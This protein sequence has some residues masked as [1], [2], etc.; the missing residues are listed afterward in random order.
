MAKLKDL[1]GLAALGA[2]GYQLSQKDQGQ[3]DNDTLANAN[4]ISRMSDDSNTLARVNSNISPGQNAVDDTNAGVLNAISKPKMAADTSA[5]STTANAYPLG[6]M[7]GSRQKTAAKPAAKLAAK[8]MSDAQSDM[9]AKAGRD[10]TDAQNYGNESIRPVTP[11]MGSKSPAG[12]RNPR[13]GRPMPF[14]DTAPTSTRTA[15]PLPPGA[16]FVPGFGAVDEND[17]IIPGYM[18]GY[19]PDAATSGTSSRNPRTGRQMTTFK[20]GGSV[21]KM[22]SGGM[23]SSASKRGDGIATKGKTRG[24]LC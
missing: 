1:A 24:K 6:V 8:R 18:G 22:A 7:G 11:D 10:V 9:L 19:N 21:K 16:R 17:N 4:R 14:S 20:K 3:T 13:T 12:N 15:R 5:D 23:T 2:L